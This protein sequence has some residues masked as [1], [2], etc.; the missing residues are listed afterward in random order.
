MATMK[1]RICL[2]GGGYQ[3]RD[4]HE[5]EQVCSSQ[6]GSVHCEYCSADSQPCATQA[7]QPLSLLPISGGKSR[8]PEGSHRLEPCDRSSP[9]GETLTSS[10]WESSASLFRQLFWGRGTFYSIRPCSADVNRGSPLAPVT[11]FRTVISCVSPFSSVREPEFQS[12]NTPPA[13]GRGR[14]LRARALLT[15]LEI[16]TSDSLV[17]KMRILPVMGAWPEAVTRERRGEESR[18]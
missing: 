17:D 7:L 1:R 5:R 13:V 18:I 14:V 16:R 11:V 3:R 9:R 6:P 4:V 10:R 12:A 2:S 8:E 15:P